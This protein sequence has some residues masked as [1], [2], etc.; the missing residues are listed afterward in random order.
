MN[1]MKAYELNNDLSLIRRESIQY[2]KWYK[3][4]LL[5]LAWI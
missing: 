2:A 3:I 4:M 5:E 1:N